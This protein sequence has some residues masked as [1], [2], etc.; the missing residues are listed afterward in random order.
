MWRSVWVSID[1]DG[2]EFPAYVRDGEDW[3]GFAVPFFG[4]YAQSRV[5]EHLG[6]DV[7]SVHRA[8]IVRGVADSDDVAVECVP[9]DGYRWVV[10]AVCE[11]CGMD[12][13]MCP[14]FGCG[15]REDA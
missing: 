1:G 7:L 9:S 6:P 11:V 5:V 3:N 4:P 10:S 15:P 8:E 14:L 12:D 13:T 2:E